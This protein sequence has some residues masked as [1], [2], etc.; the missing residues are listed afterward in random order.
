MSSKQTSKQTKKRGRPP[1]A[2]TE[3]RIIV[4]ERPAVC[5][6]CGSPD[7][8]KK[9]TIRTM[10]HAGLHIRW[11]KVD[12]NDCPSRYTIRCEKPA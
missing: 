11:S 4:V 1:G 6:M 12:C 3:D 8:T 7:R 2:K 10:E 5:P 9:E